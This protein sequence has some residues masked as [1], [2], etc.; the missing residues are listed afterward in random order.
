MT[1]ARKKTGSLT[2]EELEQRKKYL[3]ERGISKKAIA[4][5]EG[6]R[7]NLFTIDEVDERMKN[8]ATL[9]VEDPGALIN[10]KPE[11]LTLT[12]ATVTQKLADL[13]KVLPDKAV[14][15]VESCPAV[16]TYSYQENLAPKIRLLTRLIK[17]YH[18][19]WSLGELIRRNN[20]LL[21]SRIDKLYVLVRVLHHYF[22]DA[23][24]I[25]HKNISNLLFENL[26][27]VVLTFG[28]MG[29]EDLTF[30]EFLQ[31][32]GRAKDS[33]LPK[34]EKIKMIAELAPDEGSDED[35][36]LASYHR[37]YPIK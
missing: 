14:A 25:T 23:R 17:L 15:L 33:R 26:E 24:D 2:P 10:T 27:D 4:M 21:T 1:M 22:T 35:R 12:S 20:S 18:L 16:L 3:A 6:K 13:Q 30:A 9:G 31:E 11:I 34:A 19:P 29:A 28:E 32:V 36:V 7:P 8:L 5:F 37:G